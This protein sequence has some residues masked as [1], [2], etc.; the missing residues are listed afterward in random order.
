[1]GGQIM[2]TKTEE[3]LVYTIGGIG[4]LAILILN[5]QSG[6]STNAFLAILKDLSP[7]FITLVIFYM[8]NGLF[9]KSYNFEKVANKVIEKVL[10]RYE[11]IFAKETTKS[12]KE[13]AEECLFFAKPVTSFIPLQEIRQG[14]LEIRISYGTLANF[15]TISPKDTA[16]NEIRVANK[17]CLVKSK[18]IEALQISGAKFKALDDKDSAVKIQFLPQSKYERILE[19]VINDIITLLK[20]N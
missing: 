15:E 11:D 12:E 3:Y 10:H 16:E 17:K 19:T 7:L 9:F 8:L 5:L 6:F 2:H 13:N 18:T 14:V 1:M 4:F 20:D